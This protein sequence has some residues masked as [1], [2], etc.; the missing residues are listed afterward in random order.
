MQNTFI[1]SAAI[2]I[3]LLFWS[4]LILNA[5]TPN[6]IKKEKKYSQFVTEC[7][8]NLIEYGTDRYGPVNAPI[9]VSILD[10]NTKTCPENPEPLDEYYRVT[11]RDRRNPA[12]SNLFTDQATLKSMY[13]LTLITENDKYADFAKKYSGYVMDNLVD[14]KDFFWWGIHRHYDVFKDEMTGHQGNHHEIQ[15]ITHI[16]WEHLWN[17]DMEAVTK[18]IN[19]IW[20]WH[21][22]DKNTGEVNRH[23]DGKAGCDFSMSAGAYIEAFSFLYSKTKDQIWLDR[24][25]FLAEYYWKRRNISTNL[26]PDRPNAGLNRFDGSCFVSSITGLYCHSLLKAYE[27]TG[28]IKFRDQ[29][30]SY[31]KAYSKYGFDPET[32]KFWGALQ[33]DGTPIPGPRVYTDNIDS[34]EGY[35]AAQPRGYLDLWEPYMAGYQYAIYTAQAYA[36]AYHLTKDPV[37][38]ESAMQFADW[39]EKTPP[40]TIETED[41]WY[42][43]YSNNQGLKGTYADKYGRSISFFLHLYI[44]TKEDKYLTEAKKFADIAIEKLFRN[45]L[46]KGHPEKPYYEAMDGVGYLLYALLQLDHVM[47]N[48]KMTLANNKILMTKN[49]TEMT[50]DNW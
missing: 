28:E 23:G 35:A 34:N 25:L 10:V 37:L 26:F 41:T 30:I 18:Q 21:V 24:S 50:L 33:L 44:L 43:N 12:G 46:F 14:E 49:Q 22:I 19:A 31:L 3:I 38:L 13:C 1:R 45:G 47:D 40:E 17:I 48:T 27:L 42:K 11:R 20:E 5:N 2:S 15:A 32:G 29:A 7:L 36:F 6:K 9:L 39:I 8:D 16:D 4:M